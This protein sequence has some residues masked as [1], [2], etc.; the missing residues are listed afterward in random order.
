MKTCACGRRIGERSSRCMGCAS[1]AKW[2]AGAFADRVAR[3][4]WASA[5]TRY[6]VLDYDTLA[7]TGWP[8]LTRVPG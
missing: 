5:K 7:Q 1:R 8:T 3:A 6:F 4:R 2:R